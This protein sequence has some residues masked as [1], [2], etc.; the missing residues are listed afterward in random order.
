MI[1]I[2]PVESEKAIWQKIVKLI[3]DNPW[4]F[5]K[6]IP[7]ALIGYASLPYL[8]L[9]WKWIPLLWAGYEIYSKI[10]PGGAFVILTALQ[11]M[12]NR[13]R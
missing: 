4:I 2:R 13:V 11:M 8:L 3:K 1:S 7:F 12:V 5:Y 9:F 10:P 6:G